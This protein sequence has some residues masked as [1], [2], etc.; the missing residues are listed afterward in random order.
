MKD[1]VKRVRT[2]CGMNQSD[3]GKKISISRSAV[4]KIEN[5]ENIPSE[6]TLSLICKEFNVN[7]DWLK[8]GI[9][10]MY[11]YPKDETAAIVSDLLEE[12]NP[13]YDIIKSIMKTYKKLDSK[14]QK[15]IDDFAESLLKELKGG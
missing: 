6:Q 1:R 2:D 8:N 9:G 5:G 15:T 7:M 3:F 4:W 14:S 13:T 11:D 12:N 10:E